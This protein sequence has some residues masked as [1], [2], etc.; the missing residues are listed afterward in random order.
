MDAELLN[1][2]IERVGV[3]KAPWAP[4]SLVVS[5]NTTLIGAPGGDLTVGWRVDGQTVEAG[6]ANSDAA[7]NVEVPWKEALS[8]VSGQLAPAVAYM[9]GLAKP[10]GEMD[11]VLRLLAATATP[12]FRNWLGG[13][14]EG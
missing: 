10:A 8:V 3:S 12:E 2:V 6:P 11:K 9:R 5:V 7:V 13:L 1:S 4:E 14:R